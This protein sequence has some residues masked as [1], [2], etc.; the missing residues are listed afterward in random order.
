MLVAEDNLVNQKVLLLLLERLGH[1]VDVAL[2][3]LQAVEATLRQS[4]D[5]VLMDV[6]MPEMDGLEA[7]R[8]IRKALPGAKGPRIIAVTANVAPSDEVACRDAGMDDFMGKPVRPKILERMI[9]RWSQLPEGA[10]KE[11][12]GT[13]S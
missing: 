13:L 6:C 8:R 2:N 5:L 10:D 12:P 11:A 3:G 1:H 4:Y 7:T 9:Q